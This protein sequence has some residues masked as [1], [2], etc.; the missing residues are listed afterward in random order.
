MGQD[1]S[2]EGDDNDLEF[3]DYVAQLRA[4]PNIKD[5][6]P[7][8]ISRIRQRLSNYSSSTLIHTTSA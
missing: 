5:L 4:Y 8:E 6:D 7:E 3:K 1:F 2:S